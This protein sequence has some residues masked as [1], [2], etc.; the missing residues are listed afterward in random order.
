MGAPLLGFA[1]GTLLGG[2]GEGRGE[3]SDSTWP[4]LLCSPDL[5]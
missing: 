4:L 1:L 3:R 2:A 5:G